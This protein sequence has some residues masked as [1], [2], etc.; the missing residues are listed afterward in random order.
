MNSRE[1]VIIK[2]AGPDI[3]HSALGTE[4]QLRIWT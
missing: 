3:H 2:F 1:R 4:R